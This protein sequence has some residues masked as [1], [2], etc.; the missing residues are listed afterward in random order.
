MNSFKSDINEPSTWCAKVVTPHHVQ[1]ATSP[2]GIKSST[3]AQNVYLNFD[4]G[5]NYH[6]GCPP[7]KFSFLLDKIKKNFEDIFVA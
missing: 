3:L 7:R 5:I 4:E 6:P 1:N 2:C